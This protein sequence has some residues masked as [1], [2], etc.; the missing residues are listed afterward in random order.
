MINTSSRER[1]SYDD[2]EREEQDLF[3]Q[4]NNDN[5]VAAYALRNDGEEEHR[6]D[7]GPLYV[8]S[9]AGDAWELTWVRSF[10][11]HTRGTVNCASF[12]HDVYKRGVISFYM[13][14][15]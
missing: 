6:S 14:L 13:Y 7:P 1:G 10:H 3:E 11:M 4:D 8:Q 12:I 5:G 15:K 9:A 2:F